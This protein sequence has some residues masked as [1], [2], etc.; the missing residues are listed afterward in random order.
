[1][2][3]YPLITIALLGRY[4]VRQTIEVLNGILAQTYPKL[5]L[6]I[7]VNDRDTPLDAVIRVLNAHS[8]GNVKNIK[9]NE[10][11]NQTSEQKH[12]KYVC[13]HMSGESLLLLLDG[14]S[15]YDTQALHDCIDL[16]GT[17]PFLLGTCV[18]YDADDTYTG[19]IRRMAADSMADVLH[20]IC[21]VRGPVL[22][23]EH[24]VK[25]MRFRSVQKYDALENMILQYLYQHEECEIRMCEWPM[26]HC[27]EKD[28][29]DC[30]NMVSD[31]E[32]N[33]FLEWGVKWE[34]SHADGKKAA[35]ILEDFIRHTE[36]RADH[37]KY[38]EEYSRE[39]AAKGRQSVWGLSTADRAFL[40]LLSRIRKIFLQNY[41]VKY[42]L[43]QLAKHIPYRKKIKA[44][45]LVVEKYLW[46]SC[47]KS[48]YD[49][50]TG[51]Q[52][53]Y[54]TEVVYVRSKRQSG[55]TGRIVILR[56]WGQTVMTLLSVVRILC[57]C[58][59]HMKRKPENGVREKLNLYVLI[60][61]T[62]RIIWHWQA[63][64]ILGK[65]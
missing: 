53:Q 25:S 22:L 12:L 54:E 57:F 41:F 38:I 45:F 39:I 49:L 4:T 15:F 58:A 17:Q 11:Y 51:W 16:Y 9:I 18:M 35:R 43:K 47:Y 6:I 13:D 50:M 33:C 48:I 8:P 24:F 7:S 44:V 65:R 5:E 3:E 59:S 1:M 32:N 37:L 28:K 30:T 61:Y 20:K 46:V 56:Y 27:F 42:R 29:Q 10:A 62:F 55:K 26:F 21:G 64:M 63:C 52:D 36:K 2:Q 31:H 34:L 60:L 19:D 14:C 23:P 40:Q